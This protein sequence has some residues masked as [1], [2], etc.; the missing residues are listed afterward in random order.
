MTNHLI[1][2]AFDNIGNEGGGGYNVPVYTY[3]GSGP[4]F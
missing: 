1:E 4:F 3:I 2:I